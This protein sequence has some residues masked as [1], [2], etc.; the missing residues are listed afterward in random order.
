MHYQPVSMVYS[1]DNCGFNIT[2]LNKDNLPKRGDV[3]ILKNDNSIGKVSSFTCQVKVL[4]HP[5]DLKVNYCPFIIVKTGS[6]QVRMKK[7]NWKM[8]RETNNQK[9]LNPIYLRAMD[10]AEVVF[11]PMQPIVIDTFQKCNGGGFGRVSIIEGKD[12]VMLG[13]VLDVDYK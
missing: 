13:K 6:S 9:E 3:I 11:E 10:M 7:I 8:G 5:G 1:G 2:G 4:D 12:L